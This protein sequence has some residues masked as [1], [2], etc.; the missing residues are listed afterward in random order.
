MLETLL[1]LSGR[2][3]PLLLHL[4][5]GTLAALVCLEVISLVRRTPLEPRTRATLACLVALSAAA[6]VAT[7]LLLEREPA[8]G[9]EVL[10]LHKWL[11]IGVGVS[12]VFAAASLASVK[13]R[14][15]YPILLA[16]ALGC[17]VPAGHFGA[18]M[19]HGEGFLTEPLFPRK[20]VPIRRT[21][22]G[23]EPPH[24]D[25]GVR[26]VYPEQAAQIFQQYCASCHNDDKRKGGLALTTPGGIRAGGKSGAAL[27]PGD[28]GNSEMVFRLRLP[29]TDRDHMPPKERPQPDEAAIRL[30]EEW[31][32]AGAPYEGGELS[33][34]DGGLAVGSGRSPSAAID[35]ASPPVAIQIPVAPPAPPAPAAAALS[36]LREHHVHVE[37]VEPERHLLWVSFDSAAGTDDATAAR[38]MLPLAEF[39]ADLSLAGTR[40]GPETLALAARMPALRRLSLARTRCTTGDLEALGGAPALEELNLSETSLDDRAAGLLSSRFTRLS[41]VFL[42]R[43]GLSD[44]AISGLRAGRPALSLALE[45]PAD[46]PLE[47]EPPLAF[48]GDAPPLPAPGAPVSLAPINALCPVSNKPIDARFALVHKGRVIG[49]CCEQCVAE[50]LAEPEKFEGARR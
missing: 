8:Y 3:H 35:R 18:T 39:I 32:G 47:T 37:V 9:G 17:I 36:A 46:G 49:F 40:P 10:D 26:G 41:R 14:R 4:P 28:P 34:S 30:I 19:T 22:E 13:T 5:I 16:L 29:I 21:A 44:G 15:L 12:T 2:A 43:S 38:L 48:S 33:R 6:S 24:L 7:G 25:F 45:V 11:G 1:Q 23:G 27:V 50:F 42:W 31:I 20:P